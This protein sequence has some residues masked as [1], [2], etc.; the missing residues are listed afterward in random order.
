MSYY[1]CWYSNGAAVVIRAY[2]A[3]D[4]RWEAEEQA[5]RDGRPGL[6]VVRVE[7]VD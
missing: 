1:R 6:S 3:S 5:E 7:E 4:A 2:S